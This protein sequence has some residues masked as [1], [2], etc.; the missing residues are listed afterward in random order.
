MRLATVVRHDTM[1]K[2]TPHTAAEPSERRRILVIDHDDEI[3]QAACTQLR[4]WGFDAIGERDGLSGLARLTHAT[5]TNEFCGMLLEMDMPVLGGMAVLQEMKDRHPSVPVI[6]MART[7][8][9]DKLRNAVKM[10]AQEYL[11]KP[12]DPELLKLKCASVF[13]E[14]RRRM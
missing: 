4:Q 10:W 9:I 3:R 14:R 11:V 7:P 8:H 5:A 12:Y 6:V 1:T 13:S 2:Q